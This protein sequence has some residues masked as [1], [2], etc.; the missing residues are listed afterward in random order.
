VHH[1]AASRGCRQKQSNPTP[2]LVG[3]ESGYDTKAA[4]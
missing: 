1:L 4:L 3:A 2:P